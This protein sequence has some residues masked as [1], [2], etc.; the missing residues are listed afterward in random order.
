MTSAPVA[1]IIAVE[2]RGRK[3]GVGCIVSVPLIYATKAHSMRLLSIAVLILSLA[4]TGCGTHWSQ[5]FS[6]YNMA[7]GSKVER[8]SAQMVYGGVRADASMLAEL[9]RKTTKA[10]VE[11]CFLL[12]LPILDFPLS[13]VADTLLLP[14]DLSYG[15]RSA[16]EE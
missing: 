10:N 5:A 1:E 7:E 11:N 13:L 4:S 16:P 8:T 9:W 6:G 12:P 14:L 2:K 3:Q 15:N